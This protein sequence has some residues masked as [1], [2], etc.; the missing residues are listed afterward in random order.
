MFIFVWHEWNKSFLCSFF[1]KQ[2][3]TASDTAIGRIGNYLWGIGHGNYVL[4][5]IPFVTLIFTISL[6][7][8]N[9]V[10][11]SNSELQINKSILIKEFRSLD[12]WGKYK[13]IIF[14]ADNEYISLCT[15][16]TLFPFY[17]LLS[18]SCRMIKQTLK[19][20]LV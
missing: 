8:G 11:F 10:Y 13:D 2:W 4:Q 3:E 7:Y 9:L 17:C 16:I 20:H 6:L 5:C 15:R 14:Q 18:Q 19:F 1:A 12:I